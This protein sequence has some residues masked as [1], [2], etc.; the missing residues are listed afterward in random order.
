MHPPE[1]RLLRCIGAPRGKATFRLEISND[2]AGRRRTPVPAARDPT[3]GRRE[4][5]WEQRSVPRPLLCLDHQL[6]KSAGVRRRA[7]R[8]ASLI[9]PVPSHSEGTLRLSTSSSSRF[10]RVSRP[11]KT[12]SRLIPRSQRPFPSLPNGAKRPPDRVPR[13]SRPAKDGE[14]LIPRSASRPKR[15]EWSSKAFPNH[16]HRRERNLIPG[17]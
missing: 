2:M 11:V 14:R 13:S 15:R 5:R 12:A 17:E 10:P 1:Q 16:A 3:R 8:P 7:A 6:S 9:P 4:K